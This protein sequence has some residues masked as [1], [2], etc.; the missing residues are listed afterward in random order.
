MLTQEQQKAIST[1]KGIVC[2][3][4]SAGTGK[5][6]VLVERYCLIL[7]NLLEQGFPIEKALES[8]LAVTFTKKAADEMKQRV[9]EKLKSQFKHIDMFKQESLKQHCYISTIDSFAYRFLR[10]NALDIGLYSDFEVIDEIES[11]II[12]LNQGKLVLNQ[13]GLPRVMID[14]WIDDFL[15]DIYNYIT[16]LRFNAIDAL[17]F[18]K[19]IANKRNPLFEV[20]SKLYIAYEEEL[21]RRRFFDFSGLLLESIKILKT[22]PHIKMQYQKKFKY[23]LVDEFQDTTS[24]QHYFLKEFSLPDGNY[25]VVGDRKQSIY[26]FR[27]ANS[28]NIENISKEADSI[29]Y[30]KENFR[31]YS[32]LLK[33]INNLFE[34]KILDYSPVHSSKE[35]KEPLGEIFIANDRKEEAEFIAWRINR[36]L[37]SEYLYYE[38]KRKVQPKDIVILLRGVKSHVIIFEETLRSYNIP[39]ITFGGSGYYH[40]PEVRE[41]LSILEAVNN[42][43]DEASLIRFLLSPIVNIHPAT[44][45]TIRVEYKKSALFD[46]I[47]NYKKLNI[48]NQEKEKLE[49]VRHFLNKFFV[50]KYNERITPLIY[51]LIIESGYIDYLN[52]ISPY[53]ER[54]RR[55]ANVRKFYSLVE[56]FEK[57]NVF[58]S[59]QDFIKYIRE[60][61]EQEIV[62]SEAYLS[63]EDT[64]RIMNIHQAKG[65]EFPIVFI[66]DISEGVFPVR[67]RKKK[68]YI[69]HPEDLIKQYQKKSEFNEEELRLFYVAS[70]RAKERLILTGSYNRWK[71]LSPFLNYVV[72]NG[73]VKEKFSSLLIDMRN[74]FLKK[75]K[76]IPVSYTQKK[77]TKS[78]QIDIIP[79]KNED[80]KPEFR[81]FSVTELNVY[82]KCPLLYKYL[83]IDKIPQLYFETEEAQIGSVIHKVIEEYIRNKKRI[84]IKAYF[85]ELSKIEGI[86]TEKIKI[87]QKDL[88]NIF[89]LFL[90]ERIENIVAVECPFNLVLKNDIIVK[91][92]ID[93]IDITEDGYVIIDY[94]TGK[95]LNIEEYGFPMNVYILGAEE[96]LDY[97][98]VMKS[99]IYFLKE[100]KRYLIKREPD[101]KSQI[102]EIIG[103]IENKIFSPAGIRCKSCILNIL[104]KE[105][106]N[107]LK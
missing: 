51:K 75:E 87:W 24:L 19:L 103:A 39:F 40:R 80:I 69:Y 43:F 50:L 82:R 105:S 63:F 67:E 4:A 106:N 85:T 62:E 61:T 9:I 42:P 37:N 94:K 96:V 6:T 90:D 29:L 60:I 20:I 18:K 26:E 28:N 46:V 2:L 55:I 68:E 27:G 70:T 25:F 79:K 48:S 100:K 54:E 41:L 30:L 11:K 34:D 78:L 17:E 36:L 97:R 89:N 101:I 91:G 73:K 32:E 10:E 22:Y 86:S 12:F 53:M 14:K 45:A 21:K 92:I 98:P 66:S 93:R 33:F 81:T 49:N 107:P 44:I 56:K 72:T 65:L 35:R 16:E 76:I 15:K 31:S 58:V 5:T 95:I 7:Q 77:E 102:L 99:F 47:K 71:R 57:R 3:K 52:T 83:Y 59:L 38:G 8:I 74:E 88:N 13:K 84:N 23:I 1:L 64:I 104:C